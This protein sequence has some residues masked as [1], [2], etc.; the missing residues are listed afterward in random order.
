MFRIVVYLLALAQLSFSQVALANGQNSDDRANS[1]AKKTQTPLTGED[2]DINVRQKLDEYRQKYPWLT[3]FNDE[4]ILSMSRL[5]KLRTVNQSAA[6]CGMS[7]LPPQVRI[8][9][10]FFGLRKKEIVTA[11]AGYYILGRGKEGP[12]VLNIIPFTIEKTNQ[13]FENLER[14]VQLGSCTLPKENSAP[15]C[16]IVANGDSE[17][18]GSFHLSRLGERFSPDIRLENQVEFDRIS[19]FMVRAMIAGI[20]K[21]ENGIFS[22]MQELKDQG[23]AR[24]FQDLSTDIEQ[25]KRGYPLN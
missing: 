6:A 18:G 10:S 4:T 23:K 21:D 13:L 5:Y 17:G 16:S 7:Y 9:K 25:I 24:I 2:I 3:R 19:E 15:V 22:L 20:C 12:A 1:E 11:P 8:E 14:A